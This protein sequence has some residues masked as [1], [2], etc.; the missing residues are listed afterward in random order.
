MYSVNVVL[1]SVFL[2]ASTVQ[3]KV[4]EAMQ[5]KFSDLKIELLAMDIKKKSASDG[6][7]VQKVGDLQQAYETL[8]EAY[9]QMGYEKA[10]RDKI[11]ADLTVDVNTW[12]VDLQF[13]KTPLAL[14]KNNSNDESCSESW[15]TLKSLEKLNAVLF[16]NFKS[17][18]KSRCK[19]EYTP[20][21]TEN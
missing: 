5:K 6:V 3:A 16:E 7:Y 12:A 10:S 11:P 20:D 19:P 15:A 1:I 8:S 21:N 13:F 14:I 17:V 4:T 9:W 2:F 18:F